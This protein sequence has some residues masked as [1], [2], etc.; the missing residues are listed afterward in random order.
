MYSICLYIFRTLLSTLI[1]TK[2]KLLSLVGAPHNRTFSLFP[3]YFLGV[4][5]NNSKL[6]QFEFSTYLLVENLKMGKMA[7]KFGISE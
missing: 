2:T 6:S 5:K 3:I 4:K 7:I 1:M